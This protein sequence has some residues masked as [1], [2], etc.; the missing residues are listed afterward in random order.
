MSIMDNRKL[1]TF[2]LALALAIMVLVLASA[3]SA[4]INLT[5]EQRRMQEANKYWRFKQPAR[6]QRGMCTGLFVGLSFG[7]W[8]KTMK[9]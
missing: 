6:D 3:C 5:S 9:K 1:L 2:L 8:Y 4:K 7:T